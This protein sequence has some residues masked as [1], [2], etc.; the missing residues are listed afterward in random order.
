[1]STQAVLDYPEERKK[2]RGINLASQAAPRESALARD[3]AMR[4][5]K[6]LGRPISSDDIR[7]EAP[8]LFADLPPGKKA[9]F[10]GSVWGKRWVAVGVV[11]S[12]T[13]GS[14]ANELKTWEPKEGV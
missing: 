2:A 1:M 6:R 11:K 12:R 4:A 8:E 10:M 13:P 9:N 7:N 3:A 5:W 14:H